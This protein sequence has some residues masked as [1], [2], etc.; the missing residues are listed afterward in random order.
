MSF[1]EYIRLFLRCGF[2]S[3]LNFFQLISFWIFVESL[4][5]GLVFR[6][7]IIGRDLKISRYSWSDFIFVMVD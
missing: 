5:T 4:V 3:D 1:M 2:I 7:I 6:S